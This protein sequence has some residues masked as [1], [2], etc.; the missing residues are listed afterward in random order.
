MQ[1]AITQPTTPSTATLSA[2]VLAYNTAKSL[3]ERQDHLLAQVQALPPRTKNKQVL[4]I[5]AK[6]V[7]YELNEKVSNTYQDIES[8]FSKS[9][10]A[11]AVRFENAV[12]DFLKVRTCTDTQL[13]AVNAVL[14]AIK[15]THQTNRASDHSLTYGKIEF[16]LSV[17]CYADGL[18][19]YIE[20]RYKG[21]NS[22]FPVFSIQL[23]T[24][25][26][27][28]GE[29]IVYKVSGCSISTSDTAELNELSVCCEVVRAILTCLQ[30]TSFV[31]MESQTSQKA[32]KEQ[33][34][35]LTPVEEVEA[36]E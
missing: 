1:P 4:V 29:P 16:V 26:L 15:N 18:P 9:F 20:I 34:A 5:N 36:S 14:T 31:S 10:C 19:N 25:H 21:E 30:S 11:N 6:N 28:A 2:L 12:T 13:Q 27:F 23:S 35:L 7:F 17:R 22:Y 32:L 8:E 33:I 24:I 3:A